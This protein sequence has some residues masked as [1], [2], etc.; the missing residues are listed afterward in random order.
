MVPLPNVRPPKQ[1]LRTLLFRSHVKTSALRDD[2]IEAPVIHNDCLETSST[3]SE[4]SRGDSSFVATGH[5]LSRISPADVNSSFW[6]REWRSPELGG[7][8]PDDAKTPNLL[9]SPA[10]SFI[11]PK[12]ETSPIP[13]QYSVHNRLL[14]RI[15]APSSLEQVSLMHASRIPDH[16]ALR[17]AQRP[18]LGASRGALPHQRGSEKMWESLNANTHPLFE[19]TSGSSPTRLSSGKIM[20]LKPYTPGREYG[21]FPNPSP[22]N[23][24]FSPYPSSPS[25][26][27]R[28]RPYSTA[29][30]PRG[31]RDAYDA[32]KSP[33]ASW[34]TL[35][36]KKRSG[37]EGRV[38]REGAVSGCFK[39]P[40]LKTNPKKRLVQADT[41]SSVGNRGK[42][43]RVTTYLPPP[44]QTASDGGR[45]E[46]CH[47]S[48]T[49]SEG[50]TWSHDPDARPK[51]PP[52]FKPF[53]IRRAM[54]P[55]M[56]LSTFK[57]SWPG[58]RMASSTSSIGYRPDSPGGGGITHEPL[59]SCGSPEI[60]SRVEIHRDPPTN[61]VPTTILQFDTAGLPRRYSHVRR[62]AAE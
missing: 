31:T 24:Q 60:S 19:I 39:L 54:P 44:L 15:A 62:R 18:I 22:P 1:N 32:F 27:P 34:S 6:K 28:T 8:A 25:S 43:R 35:P 12:R 49:L 20:D 53:T 17:P 52:S 9:P 41:G 2:R 7:L 14:T 11:P 13:L 47:T 61:D 57:A 3:S 26:P 10:A 42:Q 59:K 46:E 45:R 40:A 50:S 51:N 5:A 29:N 55:T 48:S 36:T 21:S 30:K 4:H 38:R 33:E 16:L 37:V 56:S 58:T 23:T